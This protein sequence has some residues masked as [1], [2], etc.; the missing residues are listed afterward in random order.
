[1]AIDSER[2]VERFS[3]AMIGNSRVKVLA[4]DSGRTAHTLCGDWGP[5]I[6][7]PLVTRP[8]AD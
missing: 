1:M 8:C 4:V 6:Q 5:G 2:N 3:P 7:F